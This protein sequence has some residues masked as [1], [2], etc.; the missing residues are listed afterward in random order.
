MSDQYVATDKRTGLEVTVTG[1]FPADHEDRIRIAR[2]ANLFTRL[3][4][5]ILATENTT[6]RRLQFRALETQLELA[7]ALLRQDM[8]EAQR[9][10]R[11]TLL[12]MGVTEE[13]LRQASQQ[14]REQIEQM[15]G[16]PLDDELARALGLFDTP[17]PDDA[18]E[19]SPL[20][21]ESH[22]D[23]AEGQ[24]GTPPPDAPKPD[25]PQ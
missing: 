7:D 19:A 18:P 9:L 24:D 12:G 25:R 11:E 15:T 5:S 3:M 23:D 2:T 8:A 21:D 6:E 22:P 20:S 1:Q 4:S 17:A 13:Q 10:M 16:Q 14:M